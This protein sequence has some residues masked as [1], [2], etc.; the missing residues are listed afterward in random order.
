[1]VLEEELRATSR[2][3]GF[4]TGPVVG[5][6]NVKALSQCH[7]FVNKA[8]PPDPFNLCKWCHL[9]VT[10]TE[11]YEPLGAIIIQTI[12]PCV[13][14]GFTFLSLSVKLSAAC[15][16]MEPRPLPCWSGRPSSSA[17]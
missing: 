14:R 11:T 10:S 17:A 1:M 7:T 3:I 2:S 5:F 9:L 12:T 4:S 8:T 13:S 16:Q 6:G 15:I